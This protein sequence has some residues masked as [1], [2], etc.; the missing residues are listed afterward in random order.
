M[1]HYFQLKARLAAWDEESSLIS[2]VFLKFP[3][4]WDLYGYFCRN[5]DSAIR[6]LVCFRDFS[7]GMP[8][9]FK[10]M[11][12]CILFVVKMAFGKFCALLKIPLGSIL[13]I[14]RRS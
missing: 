11:R 2:D 13:N 7:Q 4:F 6:Y 5:I 8:Q 10:N 14:V 3:D 9:S 12:G 1:Y